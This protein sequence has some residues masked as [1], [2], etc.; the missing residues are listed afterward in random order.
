[1]SSSFIFLFLSPEIPKTLTSNSIL[2]WR[3]N[4]KSHE[5]AAER[6]GRP[7]GG[8]DVWMWAWVCVTRAATG[9]N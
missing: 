1:M 4:N 6:H 8:C 5:Q 2:F 9:L 7:K 3:E